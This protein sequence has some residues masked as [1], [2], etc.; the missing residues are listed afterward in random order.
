MSLHIEIGM[1]ARPIKDHSSPMS[2]PYIIL[3]IPHV[4]YKAQEF[5]QTVGVTSMKNK[6]VTTEIPIF[7]AGKKS[8]VA[9]YAIHSFSY[10]ELP[11]EN[12]EGIATPSF[13]SFN[14]FKELIVKLY[15][16]YLL[17]EEYGEEATKLR[18]DYIEKFN[19]AYPHLE[20]F[21]NS[22]EKADP[23]QVISKTSAGTKSDPAT[24]KKQKTNGAHVEFIKKSKSSF[25]SEPQVNSDGKVIDPPV[26]S[27]LISPSLSADE[28]MVKLTDLFKKRGIT[29]TH[30]ASWDANMVYTFLLLYDSL[31]AQQMSRKLGLSTSKLY[32]ISYAA[33]TRGIKMGMPIET[34]AGRKRMTGK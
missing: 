31:G 26:C 29:D 3:S 1:I 18:N 28:K 21:R 22:P 16:A 13:M 20:E 7:A 9:P 24:T 8:Y 27:N 5:V 19:K 34:K 12:I 4:P 6:E 11:P 25:S 14:E 32:S 30:I 23:V 17:D 15:N 33:R 2:H 10:N